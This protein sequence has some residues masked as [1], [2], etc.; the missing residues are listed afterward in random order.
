LTRRVQ[1]LLTGLIAGTALYHLMALMT[2][3]DA[4]G[5]TLMTIAPRTLAPATFA[6]AW[7]H[8]LAVPLWDSTVAVLPYSVLLAVQGIMSTTLAS[9]ALSE[10][11]GVPPNL[12]R[13]LVAQGLGNML[14]GGLA[15]LPVGPGVSQSLAAVRMPD[16]YRVAPALSCVALLIVVLLF[17]DVL[18][19]VPVAVLSGLLVTVGVNLINTWTRGLVNRV[20]R[21]PKGRGEIK[22]NLAI[23]V[24][25]AATFFFGGAPL[26]LLIG[27]ILAMVLLAV[28]LSTATRFDTLEG[29]SSRRVWPGPQARWLSE[30]R[31]SLRVFRPRGG[32]FFGTADQLA[33]RL[34]ALDPGIAY[35]ILDF[36]KL[37]TL[38]ATGCQIVASS[39]KKL[40]AAGT[41]LVLAGIDS[42]NPA[43]RA[44]IDLGLTS[45]SPD[46]WHGDLDHAL[47]WVEAELLRARWPGAGPNAAVSLADTPLAKGL[48]D[49][50]MQALQ[51]YLVRIDCEPG[52][53]FLK[54][55]DVGSALYVI[56]DGLVEIRIGGGAAPGKRLAA[57]GPGSIFGEIVMFTARERTADAICVKPTR[58]FELRAESLAEMEARFPALYAR[59]LANLNAHLAGRLI[60][61]TEVV[62]AQ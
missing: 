37:T 47:E 34:G 48:G 45:P 23:V 4:M 24:A 9:A 5:P 38:D 20:A 46:G 49:D 51:S 39:A 7:E 33:T 57:F 52:T 16:V 56:D 11:T 10:A 18:A 22:W 13:A 43:D 53:V 42:D 29:L 26:A 25:V 44:L 2:G 12:N 17:G 27:T 36:S 14:C 30:A 32:L 8:V 59:V 15:A 19:Y 40:A 6:A 28:S 41:T 62:Q 60:A 1:P 54:R 55:G 50:E 3:S 61:A 21:D 58:L 35:C 31:S